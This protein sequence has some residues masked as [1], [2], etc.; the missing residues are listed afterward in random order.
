[1]SLR[2]VTI[3]G[4]QYIAEILHVTVDQAGRPSEAPLPHRRCRLCP[5]PG[6]TTRPT[7]PLHGKPVQS[8]LC[9]GWYATPAY[10]QGRST[11]TPNVDSKPSAVTVAV[12]IAGRLK[13]RLYSLTCLILRCFRAYNS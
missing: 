4:G 1:M 5:H 6:A 2:T 8:R 10:S 11:L 13:V 12:A 3:T 9:M 7:H